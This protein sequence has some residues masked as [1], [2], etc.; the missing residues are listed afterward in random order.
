MPFVPHAPNNSSSETRRFLRDLAFLLGLPFLVVVGL[1]LWWAPWK[2][3]Q[4]A[5]GSSV[6]TVVAGTWDWTGAEG[7]CEKNPH[8]ITFSE[9]QSLMIL[10]H[11]EP[12]TDSSGTAHQVTTYEIREHTA[13]RIRG[14]IQDETRRTDAGELVVWDLIL[15][16]PD[17]YQ[18]HRTDWPP[19]GNTKSIQRCPTPAGTTNR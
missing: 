15:T 4:P 17:A 5:P 6:F 16:S 11:K 1:V 9:D 3:Y 13:N 12:W 8:T 2:T 19:F 10:T 14:F 7:F 18:W